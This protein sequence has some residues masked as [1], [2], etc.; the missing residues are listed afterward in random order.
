MPTPSP[1]KSRRLLALVCSS[2]IGLATLDALAQ[3]PAAPAPAPAAGGAAGRGAGGGAAA[4]ALN[5]G[6]ARGGGTVNSPEV[7][8]KDKTITFRF[9]APNAQSV[10]LIGEIDGKDHP[11]T[12]DANGIWSV[13]V[14]PLKP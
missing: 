5:V 6:S 2:L 13:T 7:N 9:R 12:K 14:G 4:G 11:M 10:T 1:V 3:A 8:V